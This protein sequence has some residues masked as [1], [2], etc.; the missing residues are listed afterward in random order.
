MGNKKETH[1]YFEIL[2]T[3]GI[4]RPSDMLFVTDVFQEAVAARAAG[5]EVV[6]SIR[7]GNGPLPENHGFRTIETFLEI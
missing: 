5:L 1:S 2:R 4:D 6:I 3:V 7:L